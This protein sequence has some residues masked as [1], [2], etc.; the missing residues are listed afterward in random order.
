[1]KQSGHVRLWKYRI[2]PERRADFL[3]H[4]QPDGSWAKLFRLSPGYLGTQLWRDA[5]DHD[6]YYTA[7]HWVNQQAFDDFMVEHRQP[8]QRC[9]R[10]CENLTLD[11]TFLSAGNDTGQV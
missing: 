10:E 7:D 9:D 3:R 1:M 5:D 2:R 8:Y 4:Y 11:E 6:V